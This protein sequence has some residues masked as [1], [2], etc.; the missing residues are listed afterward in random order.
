[1]GL[2]DALR[3]RKPGGAKG[4]RARLEGAMARRRLRGW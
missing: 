2:F 4:V 1:M 3:R